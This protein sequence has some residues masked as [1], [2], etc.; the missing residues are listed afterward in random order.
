M[1][2][3]KTTGLFTLVEIVA[4]LLVIMLILGIATAGIMRPRSSLVLQNAAY[5][6][7][8]F[9]A[10]AA[11][12]AQITGNEEAVIFNPDGKIFSR[13]APAVSDSNPSAVSPIST[14]ELPDVVTAEFNEVAEQ[15]IKF[16]FLPDGSA[17]CPAARLTC[18]GFSIEL[19]VS[20]LT[21]NVSI[22]PIEE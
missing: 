11:A 3:Y 10:G 22:K 5:S 18:G 15:E 12:Q 13:I 20:P 2:K 9:L 14:F 21:G 19:S 7:Q 16:R 8:L 1:F 17:S 6:L 4:V